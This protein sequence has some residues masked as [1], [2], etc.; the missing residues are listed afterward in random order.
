MGE[1]KPIETAPKDGTWITARGHNWGDRTRGRHMRTA[2]WDGSVWRDA[3]DED[4]TLSY[5]IEWKPSAAQ[6]DESA[7]AVMTEQP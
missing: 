4:T 7:T 5:L 2:Y 6:R 3:A 1:W